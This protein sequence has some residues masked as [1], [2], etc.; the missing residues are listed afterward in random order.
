MMRPGFVSAIL[1]ER[2]L[3]Q[4]LTFARA[5]G[6]ACVEAMCWPVGKAE[7]KYAGVTHIDVTDFTQAQADDVLARCAAQGVSL[8]AL[9]YYPNLLD[10]DPVVAEVAR[11]QLARVI[12]AAPLLGMC[13]SMGCVESAAGGVSL[14]RTPS[15]V[16][17]GAAVKPTRSLSAAL[18]LLSLAAPALAQKGKP[19]PLI[20]PATLTFR[21]AYV[22][23]EQLDPCATLDGIRSDGAAYAGLLEGQGEAYLELKPAD[24]RYLWL[25]FRNGPTDYPG[26]RRHFDT[27]FLNSLILRTNVVDENGNTV[28]GGLRILVVGEESDARLFIPFNTVSPTGESIA[29]ALRF[30]PTWPISDLVTVRRVS[31]TS[32]EIEATAA[33]RAV[34]ASGGR[35]LQVNES[36]FL[37][38][39]K[40]T[41]T[42]TAP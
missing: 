36:P 19:S 17:Q 23:A 16:F 35:K 27:L 3:D 37:M 12:A 18:A 1:P 33:D 11:A 32:W 13:R 24:G 9:G 30:Y 42:L 34:L 28:D 38:P 4:V 5:E 40:A 31:Q 6:F 20:Q 39:F 7:R 21:C 14:G 26:S 15:C 8:S 2:D 22:P 10:P 29:W 25:D 41:L